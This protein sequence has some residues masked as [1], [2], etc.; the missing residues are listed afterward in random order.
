M[1]LEM[2]QKISDSRNLVVDMERS[3]GDLRSLKVIARGK[4]AVEYL[5]GSSQWHFI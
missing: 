2:L 1:S 5:R 4:A 3:A